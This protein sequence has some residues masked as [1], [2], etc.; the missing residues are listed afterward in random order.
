MWTRKGESDDLDGLAL[1]D[2]RASIDP[3]RL[4]FISAA[5]ADGSCIIAGRGDTP[6]G[7]LI[8]K[9]KHFFSRDFIEL[10]TIMPTARRTGL[11]SALMTAAEAS[12]DGDQI[13]TSTN[14]SNLPMQALLARLGYLAAGIVTHLDEGDPELIFVKYLDQ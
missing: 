9:R 13:F 2:E 1:V 5:L 10:V 12:A 4:P 7:L 6:E 11:A 3:D 14:Q 8:L